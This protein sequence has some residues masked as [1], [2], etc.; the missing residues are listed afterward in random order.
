MS[1][2]RIRAQ[3]ILKR[4]NGAPSLVGAE[5]GV[6]GGF[7]SAV[8]LRREGMFLYMV[9]SWLS[10]EQQSETRKASTD[11]HAPL[12]EREQQ[13]YYWYKSILHFDMP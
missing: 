9:D 10:A 2:E 4:L 1:A 8:L 13:H 3:E 7:L 11:F 5:I 6:F 12:T